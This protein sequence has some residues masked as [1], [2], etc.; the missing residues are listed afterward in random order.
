MSENINPKILKAELQ[1]RRQSKATLRDLA[2]VIQ[3]RQS[4]DYSE[5]Y[6][7]RLYQELGGEYCEALALLA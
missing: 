3:A 6:K 2:L 1:K 7:T 5:V 4:G